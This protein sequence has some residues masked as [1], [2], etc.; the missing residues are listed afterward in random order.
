M[1]GPP[2]AQVAPTKPLTGLHDVELAQLAMT[3][4]RPAFG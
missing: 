2:G 3:A 4:D 1:G